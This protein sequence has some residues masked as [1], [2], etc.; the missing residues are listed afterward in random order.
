M[1]ILIATQNQGKFQE[2]REVLMPLGAAFA[3]LKDLGIGADFPEVGR[4]FEENAL[5][6]A[7]FYAEISGIPTVAD[8]SG[9]FVEALADE[10]GLK[11]RR[12]GAGEKASDEEWLRY[13]LERMQ[14]EANRAAK[15]VC[16]AAYVAP[17]VEVVTL[18][19]TEGLILEELQVPV[20][21]GIPLSSVFLAHGQEKVFAAMSEEEKNALSHRGKAFEKILNHLL[22]GGK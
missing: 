10:L 9:I 8:D 22:N 20:K 4:N 6:K 21:A 15:F 12:W 16:A 2:I 11:T 14:G 18:S 3:S 17:G 19:E 13:F 1:D 5:G 7:K